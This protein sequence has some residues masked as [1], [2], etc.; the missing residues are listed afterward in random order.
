MLSAKGPAGTHLAWIKPLKQVLEMQIDLLRPEQ[1][2]LKR[3]S[4]T[5]SDH[6]APQLGPLLG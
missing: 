2:L 4:L 5:L 6:P 3:N 1:T